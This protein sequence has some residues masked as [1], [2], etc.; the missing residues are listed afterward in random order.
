MSSGVDGPKIPASPLRPTLEQI[1][2]ALL[3]RFVAASVEVIDESHLHAGHAGASDGAGHFR[4]QISHPSLSALRAIA[5]HRLVYD[6]LADW[7]P[8]GIHALSIQILPT[9]VVNS[10]DTL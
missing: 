7:I 10:P 6:S 8:H 4:V 3:S 1:R 2:E 9:N 5:A